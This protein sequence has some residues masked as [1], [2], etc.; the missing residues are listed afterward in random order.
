[1]K[2]L[3]FGITSLSLGGAERVLVDIVNKLKN[4]YDITIFTLY[5]EGEF[6]K[7]L[8][9]EVKLESMYP[10]SY[11]SM[12]FI[13]RRCASLKVLLWKKHLYKK[14]IQGRYDIE[15]AFLEGPIS[16]LFSVR[17]DNA[18]KIAWIH[19]DIS[20][21]YGKS[22]SSNLKKKADEKA[23]INYD[24]LIFVSNDNLN[25]FNKAYS[26]VKRNRQDS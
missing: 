13:K 19:N 21:V 8:D 16:R 7:D 22:R 12:N 25:A 10:H 26:K 2:K 14:Y 5:S 3:V 6:E 1:M 15:I 4:S 11:A 20:K 24:E 18:R 17:S 23:Y 9:K